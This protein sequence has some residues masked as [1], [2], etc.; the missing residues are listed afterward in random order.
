MIVG[1]EQIIIVN[2]SFAIISCT[3]CFDSSPKEWVSA[4]IKP[5]YLPQWE[6]KRP[7]V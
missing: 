3:P 7:F 4:H 6:Q 1:Y 2:I 5:E